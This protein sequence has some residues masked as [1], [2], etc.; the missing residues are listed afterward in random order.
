MI[1]YCTE[2][3]VEYALIPEFSNILDELGENTPIHYW[4]TRE[5]NMTSRNVNDIENVYLVA[6]FARRPKIEQRKNSVLQGKINQYIFQFNALAK[7]YPIAVFCGIPLARNIYD[8]KKSDKMWFYIPENSP[9]EYEVIFNITDGKYIHTND[10]LNII[11]P[12]T[13]ENICNIVRHSC[14][15]ISW[16]EALEIM[17]QLNRKNSSTYIPWFLRRWPYKPVYFLVRSEIL[18]VTN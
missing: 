12:I 13:D 3:T 5:G 11:S 4:T 16:S 14:K 2:Q 17:A 15:T 7:K 10:P 6:F 8:L 18:H 9:D 1:S